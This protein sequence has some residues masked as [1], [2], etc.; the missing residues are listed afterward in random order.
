V[1]R[2]RRVSCSSP[3]IAR[4]RR[5]RGFEYLDEHGRHIEDGETLE[6]IRAL[7]IPPAWTDVWICADPNGHLQAVGT[8]AAGRRQYLYHPRWRAR[9]DQQKF[10]RMLDFARALPRVRRVVRRDLGDAEL[11]RERVLACAVRLLDRGLFR[12][13]SEEYAE[14]NGSYGLATLER[15]HVSVEPRHRL[16]FDY[17][18]KGGVRRVQAV[19][20][21]E[22]H[23]V[24]AGLKQRR[25][26][27]RNLLA[28]RNGRWRQVRSSDVNDYL[29]AAAGDDFTA[30]DFRT[31][32]ATVLA[33]VAVAAAPAALS[34]TARKR[35]I[36]AVV[37]DVA[38]HLGNTP[39]VCRASYIDPRVFDRYRAGATIAC[40]LDGLDEL[41]TAPAALQRRI[42]LAVLQLLE[43]DGELTAR[44]ATR[45]GA[46]RRGRRE[47]RTPRRPGRRTVGSSGAA[48]G[49]R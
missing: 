45:A 23:A 39:A 43:D 20:D 10:D 40:T 8:D 24:I 29:K 36:A 4:R 34:E 12:V 6:R 17:A 42:E 37:A 3:G 22:A 5:G 13:G 48:A 27:D 9:R 49:R 33:A 18:A 28:Y 47:R 19:R 25:S 11:T 46:A 32:H 30:K 7:V 38:E 31:W 35:T 14:E 2:L 41:E 26:R 15:Q 16:V 21:R 1:G 44:A